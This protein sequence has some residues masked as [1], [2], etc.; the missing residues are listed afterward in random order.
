MTT[1]KINKSAST[2]RINY[3]H[4]ALHSLCQDS[5][6]AVMV[7]NYINYRHLALH[8]L[9]QD[10]LEAV[11]VKHYI[12]I[13]KTNNHLTPQIIEWKQQDDI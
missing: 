10:S 4:L 8:P 2:L 12:I 7:K 3:R 11:M 5:L 13:N 9:C 1:I 6:E